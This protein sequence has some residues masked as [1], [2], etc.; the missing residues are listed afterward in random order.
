MNGR[1]GPG[2]GWHVM[3]GKRNDHEKDE[4]KP[5]GMSFAAVFL[6]EFPVQAWRQRVPGLRG[7]SLVLLEGVAP[8]ERVFSLSAAARAKGV[9]HGMSRVQAEAAGP[10]LLRARD[11]GEEERAFRELCRVVEG[12]SPRV[13][14]VGSP[15]NGYAAAAA[16]RGALLLLDRSG[17]HRLFGSAE[18]Y[19]ERLHAG[20]AGA[21]FV[22]AR[23]ATAP[24]AAAAS[25]LARAVRQTAC[26]EEEELAARL[27]PL[28]VSLLPC[29]PRLRQ[30]LARWGIRTFGELARLPEAALISR[31]GQ[32][33]RRLQLLAKGEA[34]HL[35]VPEEPAFTLRESLTLDSSLVLL[36]SLLFV[37]SPM[38]EALLC[39]A[40][41]RAYALR[42]VR[43]TLQLEGIAQ[44]HVLEVRPAVPTSSRDLLLKLLNL[45]LQARPP[46][47]GIV[48][49]RLQ[50]EPAEPPA[51][52][53]GLFQAEFP[54]PGR[55][56]LLLAR[57]RSIAGEDRVGSPVL[58][59]T[60]QEDAFTVGPF[61]PVL[62]EQGSAAERTGATVSIRAS[63]GE[64]MQSPDRLAIRMLRP[65]QPVRVTVREERPETLY[66]QGSRMPL[67]SATGPWHSSGC[68]WNGESWDHAAWDIT[69]EEPCMALHLRQE[70][71]SGAWFVVG[72]YD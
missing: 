32:G 58:R 50:A 33:G 61:E 65:P 43:L 64:G 30:L 23:V 11:V 26:V 44:A 7:A 39:R 37:L 2:D 42:R 52:Q 70:H 22:A 47:G 5:G 48:G 56:D 51:A 16:V 3:S 29:E 62:G 4:L 40:M 31:L 28:P 17:M 59:D 69:V 54:E 68:W 41:E 14:A 36:D 49:V 67:V 72:V 60:H 9:E 8:G 53:R 10:E 55:L 25:V 66:W 19:A 15:A 46:R 6:P 63:V 57:L 45:E 12:F 38:L 27:A 18:A 13:E 20:L 21:G 71:G 1:Q 34:E 24:N 35:L